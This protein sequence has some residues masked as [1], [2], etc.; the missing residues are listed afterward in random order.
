MDNLLP[1]FNRVNMATAVSRMGKMQAAPGELSRAFKHP[2]FASLKAAISAPQTS[3]S[4]SAPGCYKRAFA[5]PVTEAG[6]A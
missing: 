2:A 1:A 6:N 5:L 3:S 4:A